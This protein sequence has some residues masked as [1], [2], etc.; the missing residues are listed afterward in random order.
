[1]AAADVLAGPARRGVTMEGGSTLFAYQDGGTGAGSEGDASP[2]HLSPTAAELTPD[3]TPPPAVRRRPARGPVPQPPPHRAPGRV[4]HG[5]LGRSRSEPATAES[6]PLTAVSGI[7]I[8]LTG[9]EREATV[10]EPPTIGPE[11]RLEGSVTQRTQLP[12]H[13]CGA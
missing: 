5:Y 10:S 13:K 6:L 12:L 3:G 9:A 2:P 1:A 11:C 4:I 8:N 7:V